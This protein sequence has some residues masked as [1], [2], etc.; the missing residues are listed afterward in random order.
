MSAE[1]WQTTRAARTPCEV[2][3]KVDTC[4]VSPDGRAFKCWR[5]DGKVFRITDDGELVE[6]NTSPADGPKRVN[7]IRQVQKTI[8][9]NLGLAA[10]AVLAELRVKRWTGVWSY[11]DWAG[12]EVMRLVRFDLPNG[13]K[14][15]RPFSPADGGWF[16]GDPPGPLPLYR[17]D[18]LPA[19]GTVYVAEGEKA[20]DA[21]ARIGL[22]AVTSAHGS[23]SPAKTDWTPLAGREVVIL[24]DNDS[25]GQGYAAKVVGILAAHDPPA[26]AKIVNLPGLPPAGDIVEFI[27][28]HPKFSEDELRDE[29]EGI[30]AAVPF[31]DPAEVVD[32]PVLKCVADVESQAIEWLWPQRI[33]LGKIT[34]VSGDPG[35]GKSFI[36]L[37]MAARLSAGRGWP[38]GTRCRVGSAILISAEDDLAD[39]IRPR[40]DSAGADVRKIHTLEAV[41]TVNV[42]GKRSE[43]SFT[44][45]DVPMLAG[46]LKQRPD[47]RLVVI[48][49]VSAYL[50]K[51]DS[52]NNAEVRG[53][54]A[55]LAKLAAEYRVAVVIVTHL[56]KAA[57]MSAMSRVTGSGAF[58]AAARAAYILLRDVKDL[59]NERRLFLP[60]KNNLGNDHAGLACRII[61]GRVAW[62]LQQVSITADEALAATGDGSRGPKQA[63]RKEAIA[64]LRKVLANGPLT[65]VE[66]MVQA[67]EAGYSEATIK[68]AKAAL[69]IKPTKQGLGPW[70]WALPKILEMG[71]SPAA[72]QNLSAFNKP[73]HLHVSASPAG[74]EQPSGNGHPVK[75]LKSPGTAATPM[76]GRTL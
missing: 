3:G 61:N 32:G 45:A 15:F 63:E 12:S 67:T 54:L 23:S 65:A 66:V 60:L 59:A 47:C 55:P 58:V 8:Y 30:A 42:D 53:L 44:L 70:T 29:I 56:N 71:S 48:D 52:H 49:P 17:L 76:K 74:V 36:T 16:V 73:E 1:L 50:F 31:V 13:D 4:T 69:F 64:W 26:R 10:A 68:R 7:A 72:S 18:K 75:M 14:V 51:T 40:L 6:C 21:A 11:K 28:A 25:P 2:C 27:E 34:L 9:P 62:E 24:P 43:R 20:A 37:D 39:T 38:D 22:A 5:N 19:Q 41:R 35:L 57:G 33:A 46:A